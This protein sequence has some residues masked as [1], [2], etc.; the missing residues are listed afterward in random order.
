VLDLAADKAG[1]GKPL[2][3]GVYRG[4]AVVF[5]FGSWVAEVAEVSMRPDGTPKIHRI[6]AAIDCGM[7][8]NPDIVKR[9]V[10]GAIVY[11]LT[12]GL[13]GKLTFKNGGI[14][15]SNFHDYPPLRIN[16]MPKVEVHIMPS[17][18]SPGGVGEPG[19]PPLAPAVVNAVYAATGKRLRKL[20][21][22]LA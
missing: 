8:V 4:I 5:S 21:L 17:T 16:E 1:W 20:P 13:Y 14:E 9:Q 10:E 22:R 19:L 7:T 2:P 18:E 6:V 11:G 3:A 15:Q 12:A